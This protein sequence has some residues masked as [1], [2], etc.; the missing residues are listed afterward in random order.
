MGLSNNILI[1][2]ATNS[3]KDQ[4]ERLLYKCFGSMAKDKGT[5]DW[6]EGQYVVAVSYEK[7][8]PTDE[9]RQKIVAL[10]GILPLEKS[11][12]N[13]Y[14][15][16]WTCTDENYRRRG[17]ITKI[18]RLCENQLPNDH[19]P[20]YCDCW[21]IGNKENK[22]IAGLMNKLGMQEVIWAMEHYIYPHAKICMDC[23]YRHKGCACSIDLYMKE[24]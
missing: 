11:A 3:D 22:N 16:T 17:L 2:N 6:I 24:R 10:S 9:A 5:L 20:L 14:E 23:P 1:K 15:I 4:I 8:K 13:G 19:K 18:L 21:R 12:F 7:Q